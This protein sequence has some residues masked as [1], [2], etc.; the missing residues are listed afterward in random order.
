MHVY[1]TTCIVQRL[2]A[3]QAV[4]LQPACSTNDA[5][6]SPST[7]PVVASTPPNGQTLVK[8]SIYDS[9]KAEGIWGAQCHA[10]NLCNRSPTNVD[11]LH[12]YRVLVRPC[13]LCYIISLPMVQMCS[14]RF[15]GTGTL[16]SVYSVR[17]ATAV[18][19]LGSL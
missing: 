13:L 15:L 19:V 18:V 12:L 6:I 4:K 2:P 11:A 5:T 7:L 9:H 8:H 16:T 1:A 3:L 10:Y 17:I 14:L